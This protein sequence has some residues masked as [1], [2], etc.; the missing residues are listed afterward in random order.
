M[1]GCFFLLMVSLLLLQ[2]AD[3][4]WMLYL[5]ACLYGLAHGGSF[6]VISPMVAEWFGIESHG[7]L[8][9]IVVYLGTTG[10][11]IGPILAGRIFDITGNYRTA[12]S[13]LG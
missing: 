6:T 13:F 7:A 5:F 11:A 12:S 1:I 9:G 8:V 2:V 4:M 3:R 10:G